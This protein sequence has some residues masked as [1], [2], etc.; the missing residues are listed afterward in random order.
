MLLNEIYQPPFE[1]YQDQKEDNSI[2]TFKDLRKTRLPLAMISNLRAMN[3]IRIAEEHAKL[4][5]IQTQYGAK[6][7]A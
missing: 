6:P 5:S 1:G 4:E 7:S 3:D 2:I